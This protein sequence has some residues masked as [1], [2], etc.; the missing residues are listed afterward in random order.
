MAGGR[1]MK[2][3]AGIKSKQEAA[4]RLIN[5]E[6][7]WFDGEEVFF[8]ET[9]IEPFRY[10]TETLKVYWREYANWQT[11][12]KWEDNIGEGVLCWVWDTPDCRSIGIVIRYRS[13]SE[14]PYRTILS[15]F[16]H[17]EPATAE[18][19]MKYVLKQE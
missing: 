11:E 1:D 5:G 4:K 6:R 10:G 12:V 15:G 17:A 14:Y 19:V 2:V 16:K 8:D 3:N 18:E 13:G 9:K 7:F